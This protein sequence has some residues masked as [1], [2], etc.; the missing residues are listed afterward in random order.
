MEINQA[1]YEDVAELPE[2][3]ALLRRRKL[4]GKELGI[5]SLTDFARRQLQARAKLPIEALLDDTKYETLVHSVK[6]VEKYTEDLQDYKKAFDVLYLH[7]KWAL[8]VLSNIRLTITALTQALHLVEVAEMYQQEV[9]AHPN[10]PYNDDWL[11]LV[12]TLRNIKNSKAGTGLGHISNEYIRALK[13]DL[14][15]ITGFNEYIHRVGIKMDVA[16]L[17]RLVLPL[18]DIQTGLNTYNTRLRQLTKWLEQLH[19]SP[20]ELEALHFAFQEVHLV[21]KQD[22]NENRIIEAQRILDTHA[23]FQEGYANVVFNM[24]VTPND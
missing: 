16:A 22:L 24:F 19:K 6:L 5:L 3:K 12:Y 1:P 20:D 9:N 8:S 4:T 7:N 17:D 10:I 15:F 2:I 23:V 11:Y 21:Q 18:Q 13:K 14:Y